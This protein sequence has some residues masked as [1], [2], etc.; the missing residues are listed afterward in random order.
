MSKKSLQPL[1]A[2]EI[3]HDFYN[4][5]DSYTKYHGDCVNKMALLLFSSPFVVI[6]VFGLLF[7]KPCY[8]IS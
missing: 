6:V 7:L 5:S 8:K 1:G 4:I 2:S 3:D